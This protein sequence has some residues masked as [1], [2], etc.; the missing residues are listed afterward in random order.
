MG[1][2][3]CP[4][5]ADGFARPGISRDSVCPGGEGEGEIQPN[6]QHHFTLPFVPSQLW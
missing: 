3:I 5:D 1:G 6:S 4:P 2:P